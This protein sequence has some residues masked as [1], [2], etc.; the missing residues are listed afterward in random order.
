MKYAIFFDTQFFN[1]LSHGKFYG[2]DDP[3]FIEEHEKSTAL[4]YGNK[5]CYVIV[6]E[7]AYDA[8]IEMFYLLKTIRYE[9]RVLKS[10]LRHAKKVLE[11]LYK[12]VDELWE[13]KEEYENPEN[14]S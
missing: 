4:N 7:K 5:H 11:T 8:Y 10:S 2:L 1:V 14:H 6:E 9:R 12:D 3:W 13:K